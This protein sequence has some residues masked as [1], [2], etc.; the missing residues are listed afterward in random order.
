ML[1]KILLLAI[2]PFLFSSCVKEDREIITF[3]SWGSVTETQILEKVINE[4]EKEN[5][6]IKVHFIHIPQ[7]YFQKI[8]LLFAS[9]TEPDVIFVNNLYLPVY[10]D[11]LLCLDEIFNFSDF[12]SQSIKALSFNGK[13]YAVPRD[14]SNFVVYYNKDI[15][16]KEL[17][18]NISFGEFDKLIRENT[19]KNH[20]GVSFEPDIY[21]A[22][23]YIMTLG[24]TKGIE[25]YRS[26]E[27]KYAPKPSDVGSSTLTQM[28]LDK[29]IV[30]LLSG[31]WMYPKISERADFDF[32][33]VPFAGKVSAD[34]SGWAIAKS[35]K[36]RD[37]SIK[38]VKYMSSKEC[39]DSFTKTG[40]IVPARID[41][42]KVLD[43]Q[44]ERAF[45]RAIE[46]SEVVEI[47]K[48]YRKQRDEAN[49]KL[50]NK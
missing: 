38:F 44:K 11:K 45:L 34:A 27:G 17:G 50:F 16:G 29:K 37:A 43:N 14:I 7:N 6:D 15:V 31:K 1:K 24:Y 5:K 42:S 36:H 48:D 3:S 28:F 39:I 20:F 30:F 41:S 33:V 23:P 32:G 12:Y 40:L 49:K 18:D 47:G 25:Y 26:L 22:E 4:F 35:T 2:L 19:T 46:N 10:A 9:R 21:S 8:H 13:I